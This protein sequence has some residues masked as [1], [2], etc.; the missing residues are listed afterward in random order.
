M[1]HNSCRTTAFRNTFTLVSQFY[2]YFRAPSEAEIVDS[3]LE[4]NTGNKDTPLRTW[5]FETQ[6]LQGSLITSSQFVNV[7]M[8]DMTGSVEFVAVRFSI[9]TH[10]RV[11]ATL[12]ET[13]YEGS[14]SEPTERKRKSADDEILA[15]IASI[16]RQATSFILDGGLELPDNVEVAATSPVET[17]A[18]VQTTADGS[19]ASDC[20]SGSCQCSEGFI[21]NGNG[22]EEMTEEQAATTAA[23]QVTTQEAEGISISVRD[24]LPSLIDKME[25][26]CEE[27]RPGKS[28]P[29]ILKKWR[30][31]SSQMI[32]RYDRIVFSTDCVFPDTHQDEY[33][34]DFNPKLTCQA[35]QQIHD[36]FNAWSQVFTNDCE[37]EKRGKSMNFHLRNSKRIG[38]VR[39][40]T[41]NRLGCIRLI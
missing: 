8:P 3:I 32:Q 16:Q 21:D 6:T 12:A 29:H 37:K 5:L 15:A 4:A 33:L 24:W 7:E 31:L 25:S 1:L 10:V 20:S 27:N 40:R 2:C 26:V 11:A 22:C 13:E 39:D 9:E 30:R 19:V 28:R 36:S 17:I 35:I 23:P 18:F 41:R 34:D 14:G 38:Q